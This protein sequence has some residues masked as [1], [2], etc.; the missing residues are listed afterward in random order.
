MK[1]VIRMLIPSGILM[2]SNRPQPD[3]IPES[4]NNGGIGH[5]FQE[6]TARDLN[7]MKACD[8]MNKNAVTPA[9][10]RIRGCGA[11]QSRPTSPMKSIAKSNSRDI[12]ECRTFK[13]V[14]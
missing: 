8:T 14:R 13:I 7:T 12:H 3:A 1:I 2:K 6:S 10:A 11:S 9:S 5:T 4:T